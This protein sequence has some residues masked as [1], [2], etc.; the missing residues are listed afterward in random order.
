MSNKAK[1]NLLLLITSVVW[2]FA[3]VAQ[4]A[5]TSLEPFTYN[6]IRIM[7]GCISLLP[8]IAFFSKRKKLAGEH[9]VG[10]KMT[11]DAPSADTF[12]SGSNTEERRSDLINGGIVCGILLAIASNLQ[13]F[14]IY[15]NTDAGK[16]GFITS[17]YIVLV[18]VLGI[19]LKKKVGMRMWLCVLTGAIGFYLLSMAG[20]G[21]GFTLEK[22]DFFVLLCAIVFSLHIL[23]VD[24][25]SP[26]CDGVKLSCLQFFVAG[27][28]SI[29]CMFFFESPKMADILACWL[30]ILYAGVMS[31]GVGYTLQI[32]GQ[33]GAEP[34]TASLIMS[35]EAVFAVLGGALIFRESLSFVEAIGCIVI[36]AAVI[37]SQL[38]S[39]KVSAR[40]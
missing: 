5:G 17:L 35:L 39:K 8:V 25:F 24:H 30:P 21:D 27:V 16:A 3:F 4:K 18:P 1:S 13:Q 20:K 36:F 14:G 34:S 28:I 23:A 29:F 26:R 7:V 38:P 15:M 9:V 2:G 6:G 19:F 33:K 31:S 11:G 22:G 12:A 37:I 10:D 32:L 40:S